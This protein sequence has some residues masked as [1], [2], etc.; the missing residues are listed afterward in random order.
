MATNKIQEGKTLRVTVDS[1][2]EAGDPVVV[3]ASIKGVAL[4]DYSATDEKATIDTE[5]V[6]DLSVQ[7]VNDAGNSAV[8]IGDRLYYVSTDSP[9]LSKKKSGVPFGIALEA[10]SSGLTATIN[11][12]LTPDAGEDEVYRVFASGIHEVD[13]SPL[14]ESEFISVPGI[15]ATDVVLCTLSVN[16]GSPQLY[17]ISAV[18]A[19]SP[20]GITVTASGTF[21]AGDAIN[22]LVLRAA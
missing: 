8:A 19:A 9:V 4:T 7:A 14:A 1:T 21:T 10:I 22:Y 11:V 20:A 15:L 3:G 5:G 6:F 17:I 18:A 2:V 13:D 12:K 16:G